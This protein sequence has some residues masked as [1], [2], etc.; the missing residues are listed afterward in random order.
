[1]P[2]PLGE[3]QSGLG[4]AMVLTTGVERKAHYLAMDLPYPDDCLVW[5]SRPRLP[6]PFWN[7]VCG[8]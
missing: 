5:V 4:E 7:G 6:K 2:L 1:M 8:P 3:A